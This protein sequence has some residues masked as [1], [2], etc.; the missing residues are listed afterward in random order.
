MIFYK[1]VKEAVRIG[2]G[3]ASFYRIVK[4]N[5]IGVFAYIMLQKCGFSRLP[6]ELG[7]Q[8]PGAQGSRMSGRP[9]E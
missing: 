1:S 5:V 9:M 2:K 4:A 7:G 3:K 8:A 6:G